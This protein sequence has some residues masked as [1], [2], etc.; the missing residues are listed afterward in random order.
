MQLAETPPNL[1]RLL[2]IA[3]A[4]ICAFCLL[5]SASG[6]SRPVVIVHGNE[7]IC[8]LRANEPAPADGWWLSDVTLAMLYEAARMQ[9]AEEDAGTRGREDAGK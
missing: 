8:R 1:P 4:I 5:I 7:G 9:M 2:L 6:C 3:I